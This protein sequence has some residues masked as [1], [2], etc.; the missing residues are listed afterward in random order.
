[1]NARV[2]PSAPTSTGG[3]STSTTDGRQ[4]R[5][6]PDLAIDFGNRRQA[7]ELELAV[8]HTARLRRIVESYQSTSTCREVV[9]VVE[10]P[11]LRERL[12]SL[13]AEAKPASDLLPGLAD[14]AAH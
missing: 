11:R 7:V 9:W 13:V 8:K 4:R 10:Q 6:W 1:V 2:R 12:Q 14:E 5:R 3:A